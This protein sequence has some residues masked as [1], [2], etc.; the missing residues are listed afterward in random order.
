MEITSRYTIIPNGEGLLS[1]KHF[2]DQ[3]AVKEPSAET[4]LR[5]TEL[6]LTLNYF[7]FGG[8]YYKQTNGVV[9]GT[10]IRP[11]YAIQWSIH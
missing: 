1:L 2:F 7:S 3:R 5:L 10:K 4:L 6:V 9:M 8:K 11:D